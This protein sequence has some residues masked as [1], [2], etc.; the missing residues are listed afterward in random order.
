[1]NIDFVKKRK[2]RP[3]PKK[4]VEVEESEEEDDLKSLDIK[5]RIKSKLRRRHAGRVRTGRIPDV[6]KT[7][8]D[9]VKERL[10]ERKKGIRSSSK[11]ES[12]GK[13]DKE[14]TE[15]LVTVRRQPVVPKLVADHFV[16]KQLSKNRLGPHAK[17]LRKDRLGLHI[18]GSSQDE[19]RGVDA[20]DT[21]VGL[22]G[23]LS[24]LANSKLDG[25]G[26]RHD[27]KLGGEHR[28]YGRRL[29]GDPR[30]FIKR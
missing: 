15:K 9:R 20:R 19:K 21:I 27:L 1:M 18:V 4:E 26:A 11:K 24:G 8:R 7:L 30:Q 23:L 28:G 13:S 22:H 2:P 6:K 16:R 3:A 14:I 29:R 10:R 25:I 17:A 12:E 5:E